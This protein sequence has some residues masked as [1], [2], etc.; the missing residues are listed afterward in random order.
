MS[1]LDDLMRIRGVVFAAEFTPEG[2]LL[3]YRATEDFT[4]EMAGMCAELCE[5]VNI[6]FETLAQEF[7]RF[8]EMN[9]LPARGWAYSGG[10][11]TVAMGG[12]RG[13]FVETAQADFNELFRALVGAR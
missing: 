12:H 11:W 5:P 8:S 9:W 3:Q 4:D 13:V 2:R 7:M 1:S 10:N 6:M